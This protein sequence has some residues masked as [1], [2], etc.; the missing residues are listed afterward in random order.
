[1]YIV[2]QRVH[3]TRTWALTPGRFTI[4]LAASKARVIR[5]RRQ[6]VKQITFVLKARPARTMTRRTHKQAVMNMMLIQ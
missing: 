3:E 2:K 4:Q 6:N 5:T 1:M